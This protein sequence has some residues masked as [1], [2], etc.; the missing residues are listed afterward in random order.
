MK[1][2]K[3][4]AIFATV[5]MSSSIMAKNLHSQSI[6]VVFDENKVFN[7][8][9]VTNSLAGVTELSEQ[10]M[11]STKGEW[12]PFG[13][14]PSVEWGQQN[15]HI[16]GT[17]EYRVSLLNAYNYGSPYKS[18]LTA[19][20]NSLLS[21]LGT[22][23]QMGRTTVGLPGSKETFN[24]GRMVGFYD[25]G[26]RGFGV[27]TTRLTAHYSS[28]GVHFVPASPLP[29][30]GYNPNAGIGAS[31]VKVGGG[32]NNVVGGGLWGNPKIQGSHLNRPL[33]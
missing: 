14:F 7:N 15:K 5:V 9:T 2:Q 20:P 17:N 22:G 30:L 19:D 18:V 21:H 3:I 8:I 28:R 23:Q 33:Y 10:E 26:G 12:V 27:P 16:Y 31:G 11:K 29:A 6:G 13:T 32:V 4:V 1:S 25:A 24:A